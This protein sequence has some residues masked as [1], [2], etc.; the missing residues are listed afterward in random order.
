MSQVPPPPTELSKMDKDNSSTMV[1][2]A[3]A[4]LAMR[5]NMKQFGKVDSVWV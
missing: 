1:S 2:E 5:N 4:L 3:I